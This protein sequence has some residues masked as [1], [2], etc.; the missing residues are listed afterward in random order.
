MRNIW[1]NT[2]APSM[3]SGRA[4]SSVMVFSWIPSIS[5]L[6]PKRGSILKEPT[7]NGKPLARDRH[8]HCNLPEQM[9]SNRSGGT[10][11]WSEEPFHG[12]RPSSG[13]K[14]VAKTVCGGVK[15]VGGKAAKRNAAQ[16]PR[17]RKSEGFGSFVE[18]EGRG[19]GERAL[20][21]RRKRQRAMIR[22]PRSGFA[23]S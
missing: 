23:R 19:Q 8:V 16:H 15:A 2:L 10:Q 9:C 14:S 12:S 13:A 22:W 18:A 20:R 17:N 21:K 5:I 6:P 11:P 1:C 7:G 3:V 4:G